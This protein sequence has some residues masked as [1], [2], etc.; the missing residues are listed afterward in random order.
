MKVKYVVKYIDR[1]DKNNDLYLEY[2]DANSAQGETLNEAYRFDTF[3]DAQFEA[4]RLIRK[5]NVAYIAV[6]VFKRG[7]Q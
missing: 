2:K 4:T 1:D 7:K 6:P 3:L 5:N